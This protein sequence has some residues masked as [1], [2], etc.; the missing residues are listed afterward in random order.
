VSDSVG[1][2]LGENE[3]VPVRV[4]VCE[5][6][7]VTDTDTEAD[8][9]PDSDLDTEGVEDNETEEEKLVVAD[10]VGERDHVLLP[11]PER[12]AVND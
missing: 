10:G 2:T 7:G 8:R 11:V 1:D 12:V 9:V 6:A 4:R 5:G 3:I